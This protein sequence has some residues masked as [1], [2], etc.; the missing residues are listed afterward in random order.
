MKINQLFCLDGDLVDLLKTQKNKSALV[1]R[2]LRAHFESLE[3]SNMSLE[4]LKL[5]VEFEEAQKKQQAEFETKL[6]E[7]TR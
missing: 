6:K 5:R 3:M 7:I 1:N 2:L 4:E